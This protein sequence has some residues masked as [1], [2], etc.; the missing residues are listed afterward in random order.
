MTSAYRIGGLPGPRGP[1]RLRVFL[2]FIA[3][4]L[5][6]TFR[7]WKFYRAAIGGRWAPYTSFWPCDTEP[8]TVMAARPACPAAGPFPDPDC[9]CTKS[10]RCQCEIYR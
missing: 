1:G 5:P 10:G 7:R 4:R 9:D 2:Q 6:R 8:E 3:L